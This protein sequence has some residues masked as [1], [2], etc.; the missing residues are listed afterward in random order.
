MQWNSGSEVALELAQSPL[1]ESVSKAPFPQRR[2]L[3]II[4]GI[5][6]INFAFIGWMIV[7]YLDITVLVLAWVLLA[8][9]GILVIFSVFLESENRIIKQ[10]PLVGFLLSFA[11][12]VGVLSGYVPAYGTD[13]L[14]TDTYAAYLFI[15]GFNPYINANMANVFIKTDFPPGLI[16]PVITGGYVNYLVYP[17]LSVLIYVPSVLLHFQS[18]YI[19]L[20]FNVIAI[21]IVYFYYRQTGF[22]SN[23]ALFMIP[24]ILNAEYVV[25]GISGG[26]DIIWIVFLGLSY[27][28]RKKPILAGIFFGLSI[29]YK[30]I[31]AI[32][33]PFYLLF[34][35][36]ENDQRKRSI[37][38]FFGFTIIAFLATNIPF[39]LMNPYLWLTHVLSIANQPIIGAG[40]GPS[41]LAF[42]GF[43]Y[44]PS[45][46]FAALMIITLLA[47][48]FLY[49][50]YY[51]SLK[52]TFF[53][54]PMLVFLFNYR[55]LENY[56]I[57]WPYLVFLEMPDFARE[58]KGIHHFNSGGMHVNVRG[59]I[60]RVEGILL[61]KK[62]LSVYLVAAVIL[63]GGFA[64]VGYVYTAST[65]SHSLDVTNVSSPGNPY[66][67]P[68]YIT[69]MD[70]NVT[71]NPTSGSPTTFPVYFRLFE[72]FGLGST[73]QNLN[74]LLW[75]A[76]KPMIH[77][78]NNTFTI[79]PNT[80]SDL[81]ANNQT[82]KVEVYY[83]DYQGFSQLFHL[84]FNGSTPFPNPNLSY[85]SY[86]PPQLYPGWNYDS[87][88]TLNGYTGYGYVQ[89]GIK[90]V[91]NR[92]QNSASWTFSSLG[93]S[94]NL[95][96]ATAYN[97]SLSYDLAVSNGSVFGE[98]VLNS[99]S[100]VMKSFVG[101]RV[102]VSGGAQILWIGYNNSATMP[103]E[104]FINSS[105]RLV[106]M[107]NTT[108]SLN[109]ISYLIASSGMSLSRGMA[110]V[111][112]F[113]GS[114]GFV[115]SYGITFSNVH[116]SGEGIFS[117]PITS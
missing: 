16:T 8:L 101:V 20:F 12:F 83:G 1:D 23:I 34:M 81:L 88:P 97:A 90:F 114:R 2:L 51:N 38:E 9:G 13:E 72:N 93:A 57:Y 68:G 14:A 45:L 84:Q 69:K 108:I 50:G 27:V 107:D 36:M 41:D 3:Y 106:L 111:S 25:L 31:A 63:T 30:Q 103:E 22:L 47:L 70:V 104:Y 74:S 24:L 78:G 43:I 33:F 42:A 28:F 95:T 19:I 52:Y 54:F 100:S 87:S 10:L 73:Q 67:I 79:F 21:L 37:I 59:A 48:M 39:I 15:H 60:R 35:F 40:L 98:T 109:Y 80:Y 6:F 17:G 85:P 91:G 62:E 115:G 32:I 117:Q 26:D 94:I 66:M 99:T 102:S 58:F 75:S 55:V 49:M 46:L 113:A 71:Y 44:I 110:Y 86:A 116:V 56:L 76:S 92:T 64:S 11:I 65:Q 7:G 82:F 105:S 61:N 5:L 29:S 18:Y 89:N 53:A 96:A 112:F 77:S 4:A